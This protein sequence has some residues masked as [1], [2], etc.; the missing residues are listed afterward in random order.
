MKD[1]PFFK[2]S[3]A[4]WNNGDITLLSFAAQGLFINICCH[5]WSRE[6][7]VEYD[8]LQK[9]IKAPRELYNELKREG[10][11]QVKDNKVIIEFLDEQLKDRRLKSEI[12]KK[13]GSKGGRKTKA[14]AKAIEKQTESNEEANSD[15]EYLK[16]ELYSANQFLTTVARRLNSLG[17]K[18]DVLEVS[19]LIP[20]FLDKL[21]IEEDL[22]KPL[23]DVKTHFANWVKIELERNQ[24][25]QSSNGFNGFNVAN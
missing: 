25:K 13:N 6:C 3:V 14:N 5:Y 20:P 19:K 9:R 12:Y 21:D 15:K 22:D 24:K 4:E 23:K 18:C 2:F 1:L 17:V 11:F 7:V 10:I 16:N 8:K